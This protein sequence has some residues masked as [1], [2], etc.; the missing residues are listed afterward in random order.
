MRD[1][2][3]E[4]GSLY[5]GLMGLARLV[6]SLGFGLVGGVT[7]D[8]FDRRT[9]VIVTRIGASVVC[10]AIA[11]LTLTGTINV[12]LIMLLSALSATAFSFDLP[13]S[14]SMVPALV[15]LRDAFGAISITRATMQAASLVGP[16]IGG[17]LLI[18]FGVG[19][20]MVLVTV[21][22]L[23]SGLGLSRLRAVPPGSISHPNPIE[24]FREGVAHVR[25]EPTLRGFMVAAIL[26]TI[27]ASPYSQLLPAVVHDTLQA[28]ALQ[29]SWLVSAAGLGAF[30]GAAVLTMMAGLPRVGRFLLA[31]AFLIGALL[32][33]LGVQREL[34]TTIVVVAVLGCALGIYNGGTGNIIQLV[35]PDALRGR[36]VGLLSMMFLAGTQLGILLL[37]TLGS[38]VGISN[39]IVGAGLV[40]LLAA[41]LMSRVSAIRDATN[42]TV[43]AAAT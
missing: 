30:V 41:L 18:P 29:L 22:Y 31:N 39:V 37:G 35:A 6:P 34:G 36:I 19:G 2:Q 25:R 20:V 15:S 27:F 3:P 32:V 26:F 7:A 21:L 10:G 11:L 1:G 4:R 16:L 38:L 13:A 33:V 12:A 17:V 42:P 8:R 43:R 14:L 23:L 40:I 28:G 24:A 9:I 5:I